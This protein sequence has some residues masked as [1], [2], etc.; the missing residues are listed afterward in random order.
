MRRFRRE[1]QGGERDGVHLRDERRERWRGIGEGIAGG[2][3]VRIIFKRRSDA[4]RRVAI[5]VK[6]T[7]I[8]TA[9]KAVVT[10]DE[11][12]VERRQIAGGGFTNVTGKL[13]RWR[14]VRIFGVNIHPAVAARPIATNV[15]AD[16]VVIENRFDG[17][18]ALSGG[19]GIR[20]TPEQAVLF[21][22]EGDEDDGLAELI[23]A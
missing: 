21:A 2:V 20:G 17:V 5:G 3:L 1:G 23:A 18:A 19:L 6:R 11:I 16:D 22:G 7:V 14:I 13:A 8:A 9:P 12:D 4:N 15:A 10:K